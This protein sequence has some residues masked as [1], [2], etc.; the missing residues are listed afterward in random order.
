MAGELLDV[1]KTPL[2]LVEGDMV[3]VVDTGVSLPSIE[4]GVAWE[5]GD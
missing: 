3:E 1:M 4:F 5:V 2:K